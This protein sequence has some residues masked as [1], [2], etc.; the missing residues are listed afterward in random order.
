MDR[1]L[2]SLFMSL[3]SPQKGERVLDIGCG[4]GNHL[5]ILHR[6]G[7]NISGI[8]A[9]PFMINK[10]RERLGSR[11]SFLTCPAEDLPFEDNEFDI[12]MLINTLEFLDDPVQALIE[13]GRVAR[14]KVFVLIFNGFSFH[15]LLKKVKGVLGDPL[16]GHARLYNIWQLKS[17]LRAAY[18]ECPATW[19][20]IKTTSQFMENV[21]PGRNMTSTRGNSP[22]VSFLGVSVRMVAGVKTDNLPVKIRF[23]TAERSLAGVKTMADIN[24]IKGT[25]ENERSLSV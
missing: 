22:F 20:G 25:P 4:T 14:R 3:V 12:S 7:L 9:S 13:A 23:K 10:A 6:L 24:R 2:K 19:S 8:D 16:F 21:W 15:G 1:Q 18:G 17:M 5:L 11:S